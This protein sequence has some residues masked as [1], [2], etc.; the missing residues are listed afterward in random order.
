MEIVSCSK[1]RNCRIFTNGQP[2]FH[3]IHDGWVFEGNWGSDGKAETMKKILV[4]DDE[5]GMRSTI[6]VILQQSGYEL[7]EAKD[8]ME[9]FEIAWEE[10]PDLIISD[11]MME[12]G[13]GFLLRELLQEDGRTSSIPM[14]L[15]TGAAHSSKEWKSD[16]AVTYLLKPFEAAKLPQA[17]QQ[18]L[19]QRPAAHR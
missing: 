12:R 16:S 11:V 7:M 8:G 1:V 9:A 19:S 18:A 13:S 6:S 10:K 17:V 4:V 3:G 15:M 14:I 5:G 2:Y